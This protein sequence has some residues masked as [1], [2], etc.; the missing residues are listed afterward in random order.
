MIQVTRYYEEFLRYFEMA[1]TQQAECNLGSIKHAHGSV[2]DDLMR[3]VE[4]YDVVERKYAGFTQILLDMWFGDTPAHPYHGRLHAVRAPIA[5]DATLREHYSIEEW[6]YVF[7]VHRITG[8]AINYAKKPSGYHNTVLPELNL[9]SSIPEMIEAI[10][11]RAASDRPMYTSV[12]YQ[13]PAF[14]KAPEGYKRGGDYFLCEMAPDLA[15]RLGDFLV[16]GGKKTLREIGEFMFAWNREK[17]LRAY[18][19][20]YAAVIA[21]IADFFPGLVDTFS[22]FYYGSNAAECISYLAKPTK[23]GDRTVFLDAVMDRIALDTGA[24]HYDA[25]DVACDFIRYIEN[26]IRPGADYSHLCRDSVWNSS[27]IIDH[28]F[29]RQKAMLDLGLIK[30]FNDLDVH[31]S[32]DYVLSRAGVAPDD[33]VAMVELLS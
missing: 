18:K 6:L 26:Y 16:D 2:S 5:T 4:L 25:E 10:R 32:D 7:I 21:D 15:R 31:P 33:Y 30:S 19:F 14:P 20:Q 13:F 12:G 1:K 9:C 24:R 8:S 28:P 22:P 3:H 23:R 29:G 17:G 11:K 27:S